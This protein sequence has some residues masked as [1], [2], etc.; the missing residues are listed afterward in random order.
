MNLDEYQQLAIRTKNR[1]L[2]D[3]AQIASLGLG[4][5]GEAGEV[6]DLIKKFIGH[7]HNLDHDKLSNELGDTLWYIA[8]IADHVGISLSSIAEIN[9]EKLKKRYPE[10]FSEEA[11]K[12]RAPGDE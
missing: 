2:N 9:I 11:S 10:G 5:T 4:V 6:A 12:H 7:G 3:T 8:V 1:K